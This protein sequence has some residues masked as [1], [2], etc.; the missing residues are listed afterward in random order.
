[1]R[2]VE[3]YQE[4]RGGAS[5][6][7]SRPG[8]GFSPSPPPLSPCLLCLLTPPSLFLPLQFPPSFYTPHLD[9]QVPGSLCLPI[10]LRSEPQEV[11]MW[12]FRLFGPLHSKG[13]PGSHQAMTRSL[14]C[15]QS[16][17]LR[18]GALPPLWHPCTSLAHLLTLSSPLGHS[19]SFIPSAGWAFSGQSPEWQ[20][21]PKTS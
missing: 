3:S 14:L 19:S 13:S 8:L 6:E 17:G 12:A 7:A 11:C 16:S 9:F 10:G 15:Q 1:M 20:E 2:N 21:R 18:R 4:V 5:K